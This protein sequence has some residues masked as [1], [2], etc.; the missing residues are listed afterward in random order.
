MDEEGRIGL[1]AELKDGGV[2]IRVQDEGVGI[3]PEM[4]PR[5]FDLFTQADRS[6]ARSEGGLGIGLALVH[7]LVALHGGAV[8]AISEGPGRGSEF[9]V[10]LPCAGV[11]RAPEPAAAEAP[12]PAASAGARKILV[13]DDNVDSAETLGTILEMAGH[14]VLTAHDGEAALSMAEAHRPEVVLLDIGLPKLDGYEVARRLRQDLRNENLLLIAVTGYGKEEDR[15]R[16]L[17]AGFDDH[18]IKPVD[19]GK[20]QAILTPAAGRGTWMAKH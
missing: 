15:N 12:K 6:L 4:L 3:A 16:G 18:L 13:V 20:L 14:Q 19:L 9:V 10:S 1:T 17:E 2:E 8:Q 7:R 11:E 5:V